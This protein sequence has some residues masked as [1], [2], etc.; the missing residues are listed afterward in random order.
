MYIYGHCAALQERIISRIA[1]TIVKNIS[2]GLAQMK[3]VLGRGEAR[4]V[5]EDD[6]EDTNLLRKIVD[7]EKTKAHIQNP[8]HHESIAKMDLVTI[9][10]GN[11]KRK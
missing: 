6:E 9:A 3:L 1:Y 5:N 4:L 2:R 8:E 10:A 7:L 11:Q